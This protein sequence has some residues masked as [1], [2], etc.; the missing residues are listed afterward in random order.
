MK[1]FTASLIILFFLILA[2]IILSINGLSQGAQDLNPIYHAQGFNTFLTVKVVSA[3]IML[4]LYV[5]IYAHIRRHYP[6]HVKTLWFVV[7]ILVVFYA[8]VVA[9]NLIVIAKINR[10]LT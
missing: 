7:F 10:W 5:G 1:G 9:N 4:P 8:F 2:D 3:L 6:T